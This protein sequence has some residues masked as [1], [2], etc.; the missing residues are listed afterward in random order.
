MKRNP[1]LYAF[2]ERS[3]AEFYAELDEV[4]KRTPL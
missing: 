1:F 4:L 3:N 2:K